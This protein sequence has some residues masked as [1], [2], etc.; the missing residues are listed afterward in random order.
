MTDYWKSNL[1]LIAFCLVI[2]CSVSFLA[3]VVFVEFFNRWQLGGYPLGFWIA[4][5]GAIYCFVGL[6]FFYN[7]R[8]AKL[9]KKYRREHPASEE[10]GPC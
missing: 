9:D 4:Q 1:R 5:Q 3:G 2:W 7:Y 6:I 10:S 8:V